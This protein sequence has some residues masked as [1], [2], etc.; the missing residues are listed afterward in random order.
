VAGENALWVEYGGIYSVLLP[1]VY[2][3]AWN[4]FSLG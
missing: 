1:G 4:E 3:I 2:N